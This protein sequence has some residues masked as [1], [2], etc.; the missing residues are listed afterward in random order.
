MR[1]LLLVALGLLMHGIH[2][3]APEAGLGST[4]GAI[5]ASFGYLLLTAFLLGSLFKSIGLPKLTGYLTA[6]I[7]VG[8]EVLAL[9]RAEEMPSLRMING[10]A[11]ALIAL[12]A[13]VEM[14]LRAMRPLARSILWI[15]TLAV[16]GTMLLLTGA[17]IAAAPILP[18]MDGLTF[19]QIAASGLVLAV[20]MT[21]MSP[22]VVVALR[23]ETQA[24]GPL[25]RTVLGVVII[26]DLVVIIMFAGSSA[27]AQSSFGG[28]ADLGATLGLLAWEI[29][30]SLLTGAVLGLIIYAYL[31]MVDSGGAL[32]LL[33]VAFVAAE[34]GQ[35]V[36]FDPLLMA[37]AAGLL[38]RN[39]TS[40]G[41]RL[42]HAIEASALPVYVIFFAVAGAGIHLHALVAVG[43]P[44]AIF[45][46]VRAAGF[47][48]GTRAAASI[49]G[50]PEVVRKFGGV[51]LMPQAGLALALAIILVRS[52]PQLG[53]Q[54]AALIF[55]IVAIN[56][57]LAPV[58]Y[59]LA[60]LRSGEAG[61]LERGAHD[62]S[63]GAGEAKP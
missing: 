34:V 10:L 12:T 43:V 58:A 56:E 54:S 15:S 5:T 45:V 38:V 30:G 33:T 21:A 36:H 50:A 3:F 53:P 44:A 4:A 39:L 42:L 35:R 31:R 16:V 20:V 52:F 46:T 26:A 6:G 14:D 51:G 57:L 8:P 11:I 61:K 60:L 22:A 23:D 1:I 41:D 13:G 37:L 48:F 17:V 25:T 62:E 49:A 29:G 24:D 59:R 63:V 18:F 19:Q 55:G 47:Y 32:F 7:L 2:Q 40:M 9:V 28:G 27:I